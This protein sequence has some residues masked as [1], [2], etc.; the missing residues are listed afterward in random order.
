MGKAI[1]MQIG[2]K[3]LAVAAALAVIALMV[4]RTVAAAPANDSCSTPTV[5]STLPFSDNLDV[6]GAT[7]DPTDPSICGG[8]QGDGSVWYQYTAPTDQIIGATLG[9]STNYDLVGN[10]YTGS[11]DALT[12]IA[13]CNHWAVLSA[14]ETVL[15]EFAGIA[16]LGTT[17][18]LNVFEVKTY[19][20]SDS[21]P[22]NP[23]PEFS[24]S[25]CYTSTELVVHF[26]DLVLALPN[27]IPPGGAAIID[28]D[29][30]QD[31]STGASSD[32]DDPSTS[33][34]ALGVDQRFALEFST[35]SKTFDAH[36]GLTG[37]LQAFLPQTTLPIPSGYELLNVNVAIPKSAL[38]GDDA[39]NVAAVIG[40]L[41]HNPF[42]GSV[43]FIPD[44]TAPVN[45]RIAT[46]A[47]VVPTC[48]A[49]PAASCR[50]TVAPGKSALTVVGTKTEKLGWTWA[51]AATTLTEFGSP[52]FSDGYSVCMYDR[53][54]GNPSLVWSAQIPSGSSWK[55][56]PKGF[57]F[58]DK[59]GANAGVEKITLTSGIIGKAK[60]GV[61]AKGGSFVPPALPL[62]QDPSVTLQLLG[63]NGLCWE[64][65]FSTPAVKS[66]GSL[67]KD[68]SD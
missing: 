30:D 29:L 10:F 22:N 45:G 15:I 63:P 46:Q 68:K 43:T 38:G 55:R 23:F 34:T 56:T 3:G 9:F 33:V 49:T 2:M 57:V 20:G 40:G 12:D 17:L 61:T 27:R 7:T 18:Q 35:L 59:L 25:A 51:G 58:T 5:I 11:C 21:P 31:P 24:T 48:G 14:G 4:P 60:F 53:S 47:C 8:G 50:G 32:V 39:A 62:V 1:E 67:F 36:S 16:G 44:T 54:A 52:D 13:N 19:A 65:N 26:P 42:D 41:Y 64:A 6:T 66:D 28:L 37:R